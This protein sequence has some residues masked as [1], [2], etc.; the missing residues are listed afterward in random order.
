MLR[1]KDNIWMGISAV[2]CLYIFTSHRPVSILH[3]HSCSSETQWDLHAKLAHSEQL[4]METLARRKALIA[5]Y[6]DSMDI[7]LYSH[8]CRFILQ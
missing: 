1:L 7:P 8:S 6:G 3:G 4:Y 5:D 2:L